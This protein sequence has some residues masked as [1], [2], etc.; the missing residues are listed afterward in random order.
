MKVKTPNVN[1]V[2]FVRH[3]QSPNGDDIDN[4][5]HLVESWMEANGFYTAGFLVGRFT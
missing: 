2:H 4:Q 3:L 1:I 5:K